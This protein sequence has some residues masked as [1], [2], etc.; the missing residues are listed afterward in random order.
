MGYVE[1]QYSLPRWIDLSV[2]RQGMFDD[3]FHYIPSQGWMFLPLVVYHGGGDAAMF[4]PLIEHIKVINKNILKTKSILACSFIKY[5][6]INNF[7]PKEYEWGLAQYF[8]AG[9]AACYRGTRVYDTQ[10][11]MEVVKKW[12]SFY[13]VR[14]RLYH[15]QFYCYVINFFQY[16]HIFG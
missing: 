9:V 11:T 1:E 7:F 4:E 12:V 16:D 6:P 5:L 8:G 13:K 10:K 3:T 14:L 2:S 15:V